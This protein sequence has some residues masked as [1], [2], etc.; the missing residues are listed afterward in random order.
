[1]IRLKREAN[2]K[3]TTVV[4]GSTEFYFS[5]ETIVGF[6][7]LADKPVISENKWSNT[8][9]KHLNILD[10]EKEYRVPPQEFE[11]KLAEVLEGTGL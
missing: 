10:P 11:K 7:K 6:Q 9:G 4:L 3:L 2:G 5:Y 8:T 1:M